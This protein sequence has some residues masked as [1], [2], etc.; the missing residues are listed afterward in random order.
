[1]AG[2][3]QQNRVGDLYSLIRF[4]RIDP[5]AHYFCRQKGCGCKSIHYRMMSGICQDCNHRSFSH[6]SHFNR[7]ILTPIQR[8][9]Y[10]GDGRRAMFKLKNEVL[11]KC[12]LRRTKET[13]AEDMNLPPRIVTIR[14]VRLHPV[15]GEQ[16]PAPCS[17]ADQVVAN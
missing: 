12:L 14:S 6:Y 17:H 2:I 4:L 13:R 7:H 16:R 3:L 5:V 1:M 11:D 8:D 10:T 9:G 15:E